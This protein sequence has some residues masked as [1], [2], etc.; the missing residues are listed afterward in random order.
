M[1]KG[2]GRER[3]EGGK[4]EQGMKDKK[5]GESVCINS[6]FSSTRNI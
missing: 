2:E 3:E 5:A 4:E 1:T 6:M